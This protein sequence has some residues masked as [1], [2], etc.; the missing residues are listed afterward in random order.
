MSWID[1]LKR[2]VTGAETNDEGPSAPTP[3]GGVTCEQ[4]A[5]RLFEFLDGELPEEETSSLAEHFQA[6][7]RCYPWLLH[8]QAFRDAMVRALEGQVPPPE[9][10][11]RVLD[12][13]KE[14]GFR[15]H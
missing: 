2:L 11:D 15:P 5:E 1:R 3:P 10:G 4:A 9:L 14:E 13:L 6:C 7:A 12:A 8:E